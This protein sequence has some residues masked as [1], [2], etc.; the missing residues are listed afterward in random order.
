MTSVN[1]RGRIWLLWIQTNPKNECLGLLFKNLNCGKIGPK[2]GE[3]PSDIVYAMPLP[4][5]HRPPMII[6]NVAYNVV[7]Y[8]AAETWRVW[9]DGKCFHG[10]IFLNDAFSRENVHFHA[11]NF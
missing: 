10:P 3:N 9:G 11:Q 5:P 1:T 4:I 8:A 6:R 2:S 7:S